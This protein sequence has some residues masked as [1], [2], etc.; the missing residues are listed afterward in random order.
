MV[1]FVPGQLVKSPNRA[2]ALVWALSWLMLKPR[3][4]GRALWVG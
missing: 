2:D 4:Q 3:S 1:N